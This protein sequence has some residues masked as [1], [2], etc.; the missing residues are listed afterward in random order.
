MIQESIF[1]KGEARR[2]EGQRVGK[3]RADQNEHVSG[4][5]VQSR[6]GYRKG[7]GQGWPKRLKSTQMRFACGEHSS[8]YHTN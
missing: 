1:R 3:R 2:D 8:H 4:K 6:E 5:G 7:G